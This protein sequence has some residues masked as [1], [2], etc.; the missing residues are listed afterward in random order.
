M[1]MSRSTLLPTL[2]A[3][4]LCATL[5]G[6]AQI[7]PRPVTASTAL[8]GVQP[9]DTRWQAAR[10]SAPAANES[11]SARPADP[12]AWWQRFDDP[13]VAALVL[14]ATDGGPT[15]A[16]AQARLDRA[17]ATQTAAASTLGP[18]LTAS[19]SASQGRSVPRAA[20]ATTTGGSLQA[21]WELDLFGAN[22]AAASAAAERTSASAADLHATRTTLAAETGAAVIALRA[23]Q[24]QAEQSR[25]DAQSR[26]TT[27]RLTEQSAGAGFAAPA[28][29]AL[30]RAGAASAR[31]AA[32]AQQAQCDT[33][34]K[35]LVEL[36][37]LPEATL[38]ERLKAR[39]GQVPQLAGAGLAVPELPA[40]L[41]AQ[42]P[43]VFQAARLL[44]AAAADQSAAAARQWPQISLA[45]TLG[46][47]SLRSQGETTRGTV[48]TLGPLSI[49]LP[50]FDGGARAAANAQARADYDEALALYQSHV[51]RAVREV[52]SA[53]VALDAAGSR[54][55][56][57]EGAA[58]DFEI[59]LRATEAR[60]RAGL[61]SQF[62]LE[63]ARRNALAAQNVLIDLRRERSSAWVTLWRSL[64]GGFV[65]DMPSNLT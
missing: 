29:A 54:Q 30:A 60:W 26:S 43:D 61:A 57:A 21:S 36:T 40:S 50:L 34:I 44:V 41:L 12:L 42:R 23:C 39:S 37:A 53:L 51:R 38:R 35:T 17:R 15:L 18:Q 5:A 3:L 48:W 52:E 20:T 24:A 2:T 16:A 13:E 59:S 64:G 49:S 6:C 31:N 28:D 46:A 1:T 7:G 8:A 14:A 55:A 25:L 47:L 10:P 19:A 27:A 4:A 63:D 9:V 58:R 45:G 11:T 65:A 62:E 22:R 33:L 56:D 32:V